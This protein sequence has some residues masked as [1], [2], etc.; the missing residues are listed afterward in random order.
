M[1]RRQA[2]LECSC[3][4]FQSYRAVFPAND[5]R[6][7]CAHI[8]EKLYSTKVERDFELIVQLL[9]R[10]GRR[11]LSYRL[12]ADALGEFA[13]GQPFGPESVRAIGTVGGKPVLATYNI[14]TE[15]WSSGE[16]DLPSD[17]REAILERMRAAVPTAFGQG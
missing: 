1:A 13:I 14:E 10:Y 5:A 8:Y 12:V 2:R 15:D 17:V 11:M 6:R 16:T 4:D 3:S 9:I 7:I